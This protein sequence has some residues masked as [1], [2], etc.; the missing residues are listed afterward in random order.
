MDG[1]VGVRYTTALWT[2]YT[3][4]PVCIL[5]MRYGTFKLFVHLMINFLFIIIFLNK[6][7]INLLYSCLMVSLFCINYK[8]EHQCLKNRPV[9]NFLVRGKTKICK[10]LNVEDICGV[11]MWEESEGGFAGNGW[12]FRFTNTGVGTKRLSFPNTCWPNLK[13]HRAAVS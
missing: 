10:I 4:I 2:L 12:V 6:T 8:V 1:A 13:T 11:Q 7:S 9:E 5:D 3:I